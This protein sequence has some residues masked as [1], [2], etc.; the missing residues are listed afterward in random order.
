MPKTFAPLILFGAVAL[1][2]ACVPAPTPTPR[3]TATPIA[4][5]LPPTATSLPA[6]PTATPALPPSAT[7]APV[8]GTPSPTMTAPPTGTPAPTSTPPPSATPT[9][10]SPPPSPTPPPPEL[11]AITLRLVADGFDEPVYLTQANDGSNRLFVVERHGKIRVIQDGQV[12]LESFLDIDGRVGSESREQGLLSL[13]FHPDFANNRLLFVNYTDNNGDTVI[14][15]YQTTPDG[16][17]VDPATARTLLTIPQPFDNHNGGQLQFGPQDGYLYI[18][19][20]DGG[21]GGDPQGNGQN[22]ATLLGKML[23]I[24]VDVGEPYA[25]PANNPFVNNP[26]ARSEIW[27]YGLR[28]PWRFSFDRRT[29]DVYI[30]DVGQDRFEEIDFE[31]AGGAGGLNYGWAIMEG[32]HCFQSDD[33]DRTGLVLPIAEYGREGGCSVTGG[34]VYRG[35]RFPTL[36]GIYFYADF[37][38]GKIWGLRA[39]AAPRE[40][41]ETGLN[42][43]SFGQDDAGEVYVIDLGGGVYRLQQAGE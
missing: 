8:A 3:P 5:A 19:A 20:G 37:C 30:A 21:A 16:R 1:L 36:E 2:A 22:L 10:Q 28:N 38:S 4:T 33:C 35:S 25:V 11:P 26:T 42:I 7:P 31:P 18:G 14:A 29:G 23:R 17:R 27:A 13:A 43:S 15:R 39:G 41:L 9:A 32:A 6:T 34:Y 12:Q 24:D 40:L